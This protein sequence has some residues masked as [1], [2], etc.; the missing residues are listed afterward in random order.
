[1]KHSRSGLFLMEL[2][3]SILFFSVAGAVCI[4]LFV[5]SHNIS[6]DTVDQNNA[7]VHA[8]NLANVW[9]SADGDLTLSADSLEHAVL[10]PEENCIRLLFDSDWE[11]LDDISDDSICYVAELVG[12]PSQSSD[13]L[14]HATVTVLRKPVRSDSSEPDVIFS[15]ELSHHIAERRGSYE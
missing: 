11:P 9:L 6:R 12:E 7:I 13:G 8:Q 2:I 3:I 14:L 1:M 10:L 4:Q 5:K 15:L